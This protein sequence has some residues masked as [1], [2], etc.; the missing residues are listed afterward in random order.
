MDAVGHGGASWG[1]KPKKQV[2][3]ITLFF[4]DNY[5]PSGSLTLEYIIIIGVNDTY[6]L[7]IKHD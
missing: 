1:V 3:V 5:L 2:L 6:L 7:V 4:V